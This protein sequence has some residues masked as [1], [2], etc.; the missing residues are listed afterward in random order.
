MTKQTNITATEARFPLASLTLS[1]IN[2][3]QTVPEGEIV[4]LAESI[5]TV[6]LIQ[7]IAGLADGKGGAEIV[8]G[9]RR[10]RALQYLAEQH[11]DLASIRPELA[12]PLVMIARDVETAQTWAT[13]ENIT[14]KNLSPAEEIRAYGKMDKAGA[15]ASGIARAFAVT[16]AHVYKR[17]KLAGLPEQVIDALAATEINLGE[18]AAFTICDDADLILQVLEQARKGHLSEYQIKNMLKPD[19]VSASDRR[20]KY[21]GLDAYKEAGGRV[22]GDLFADKTLLDD[23]AILDQCFA[24]KLAVAARTIRQE[25]GW[26][27]AEVVDATY[28]GGYDI[29]QMKC[30]RIYAEPGDLTEEQAERYDELAELAEAEVLDEAGEAE[31][32]ALQTILDGAYSDVQKDC[33][34]I[35]LHVSNSGE[36]SVVEGLV[37]PEDKEAAVAAGVLAASKHRK[38]DATETSS[39]PR[40]SQALVD[41]LARVVTGARQHA[42]VNDPDL[43]LALLAFQ[44]SG[45]TKY[46]NPIGLNASDVP[47]W[48]TTEASGYA[49]D[50]RLTTPTEWDGDAF[51]RDLAKAFRKFRK[52]GDDHVQAELTRHLAALLSG[53]DK[54]LK[55]LIDNE[56][57]TDIR[58]VWTPT[59][60][61][62][63]SRIAGPYLNEIWRTVLGLKAGNHQV[64][65]FESLKVGEKRKKL[66][67]LFNDPETRDAM[68]LS[69]VVEKRIATWVP[70]GMV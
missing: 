5:W 57:K 18:A 3:R 27:W 7:S 22:S 42:A 68:K 40:M 49:L 48:P 58:A 60:D 38:S 44:V 67:A 66:D 64:N 55:A 54:T 24:D 29:D 26:K 21:I 69:K 14:R 1:L 51:D 52:K 31:L 35:I 50:E 32:E 37:K 46:G 70:E 2:P 9:G 45:G 20:A 6:G 4:E 61:N 30:A 59:F 65:N 53:G 13:A 36:L 41:D 25:Q 15:P 11:D 19:A 10:L 34:G 16:E 23:E 28:F 8:A 33:A 43:I 62:F 56:V 12:N 63:F 39:K 47:N 17:L